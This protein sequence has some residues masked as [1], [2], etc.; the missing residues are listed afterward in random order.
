MHC[1]T[2]AHDWARWMDEHGAGVRS[3]GVTLDDVPTGR[4][5][6]SQSGWLLEVVSVAGPPGRD[7]LWP[8]A[9]RTPW[10]WLLDSRGVLRYQGH[11]QELDQLT[12]ALRQLVG[13]S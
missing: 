8:V 6:A 10:V 1:R 9:A 11:G 5:F 13:Q 2:V 3:V 4:R 12:R 7:E